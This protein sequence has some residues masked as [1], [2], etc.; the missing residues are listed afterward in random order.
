MPVYDVSDEDNLAESCDEK[1]KDESRTETETEEDY[2][3]SQT[4]SEEEPNGKRIRLSGPNNYKDPIWKKFE[5]TW[6]ENKGKAVSNKYKQCHVEVSARACRMKSHIKNC[7]FQKNK[8]IATPPVPAKSFDS[9][10]SSPCS[11]QESNSANNPFP[12]AADI[13]SRMKV[14][15]AKSVANAKLEMDKLIGKMIYSGNLPFSFAE[16]P[17]L[18]AL[19][20]KTQL[21]NYKAP[22]AHRIGGE[23]LNEVYSEC[24]ATNRVLFQNKNV[25]LSQDGWSTNQ[26]APVIC[27]SI[28][29]G[30]QSLMFDA[31][32]TGTNKKDAKYCLKLLKEAID[33]AEESYGCKVVAIVTDNC[34]VMTSMRASLREEIGNI[35]TYG[36][37]A[38]ILNLVGQELTD[39]N[40]IQKIVEVQ[41]FFKNHHFES[42]SLVKLGGIRP[43]TPGKTRWNS[44]LDTLASYTKN[45]LM[46]L[47]VSRENRST[48]KDYPEILE[49]IN[50]GNIYADAERLLIK[51]KPVATALDKVVALTQAQ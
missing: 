7:R 10:V 51:L 13:R 21:P 22:S 37:V 2:H 39:N 25:V 23:L 42:A 14:W 34:N 8:L 29:L 49:T 32:A 47:K 5:T 20:G 4:S 16:N 31:V 15:S 1:Q 24:E 12:S 50:D 44:Q 35:H 36:C 30:A 40:L 38:H 33:K 27:H 11:S 43:I 41:K 26:N 19:V 6:G 17:F 28:Q 18:Q 48:L 45:H 9:P 46:Y 3:L